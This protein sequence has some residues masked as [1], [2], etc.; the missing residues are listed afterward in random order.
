MSSAEY[1]PMEFI[2]TIIGSQNII[3]ASIYKTL[4]L[5]PYTDKAAA[6]INL[7]GAQTCSDKLS[8]QQII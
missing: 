1:N 7:Y 2:K 5:L 4:K 8:L 3:D 6:P